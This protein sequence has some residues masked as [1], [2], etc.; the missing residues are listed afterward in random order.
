MT[1]YKGGKKKSKLAS[2]KVR[3]RYIN[4]TG[5]GGGE[6]IIRVVSVTSMIVDLKAWM[7]WTQ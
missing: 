2:I 6:R 5:R 1:L 3:V 4:D 7:E